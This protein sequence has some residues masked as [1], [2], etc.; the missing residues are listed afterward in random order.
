GD[1]ERLTK[2]GW[3]KYL[4]EQLHPERI[5]NQAVEQ[6]LQN[7]ESAHLSNT[8]LAKN[9]PP[10]Q[11][12]LQVLKD[13]GIELPRPDANADQSQNQNVQ[14]RNLTKKDA[15]AGFK[16]LGNE[17]GQKKADEMDEQAAVA[18]A[19]NPQAGELARRREAY[20]V[21]KGMG[22]RPQGQVVQESQQ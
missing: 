8:E 6:R 3:E 9:Y 1:L 18:S 7:I 15:K 19:N 11:V 5:S 12:L 21:L 10:P 2:L 4:D 17:V 16:Q 22:Y 20:Q 14:Q 13:R